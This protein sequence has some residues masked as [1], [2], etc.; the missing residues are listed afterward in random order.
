MEKWYAGGVRREQP[1]V[2]DDK[3]S[4]QEFAKENGFAVKAFIK[5]EVGGLK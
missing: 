5:Y 2:M 3:K 4:V 1:L